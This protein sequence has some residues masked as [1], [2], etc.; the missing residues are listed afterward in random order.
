MMRF[1][2]KGLV[3]IEGR[4]DIKRLSG[5]VFSVQSRVK[6]SRAQTQRRDLARI[7]ITITAPQHNYIQSGQYLLN[8]P[9][10]SSLTKVIN[11]TVLGREIAERSTAIIYHI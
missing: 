9:G 5:T 11:I 6:S 8:I 7:N 4:Q 10:S 2:C 3:S 1:A